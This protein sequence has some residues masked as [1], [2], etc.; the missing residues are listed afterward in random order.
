ML[1]QNRQ[2]GKISSG[3]ISKVSI[4]YVLSLVQVLLEVDWAL[5]RIVMEAKVLT[6]DL[7]IL[8]LSS[9]S[10]SALSVHLAL[11]IRA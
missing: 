6:V 1:W 4:V 11:I 9:A 7:R 5:L 3:R 10:I 8:A 2:G